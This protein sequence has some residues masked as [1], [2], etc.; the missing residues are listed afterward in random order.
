MERQ[1]PKSFRDLEWFMRTSSGWFDGQIKH[2]RVTDTDDWYI[3][4]VDSETI[5]VTFDDE[6]AYVKK[7][8][9]I[10]KEIR[11]KGSASLSVKTEPIETFDDFDEFK[12]SEYWDYVMEWTGG[13]AD[14]SFMDS[15]KCEF[16]EHDAWIDMEIA[17]TR[18]DWLG[19]TRYTGMNRQ[20]YIH[21]ERMG[22]GIEITCDDDSI[23]AT[24]DE[25]IES[26]E[27]LAKVRES[28]MKIDLDGISIPFDKE[29]DA[30]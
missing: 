14:S 12:R 13:S 19:N 20:L 2:K 5:H 28:G 27:L 1:E 24:V 3:G 25:L 10:I 26:V 17:D 8:T 16:S 29:R 18:T 23:S 7:H 30:S 4:C 15:G 11:G 22:G 9:H 21:I 6:H